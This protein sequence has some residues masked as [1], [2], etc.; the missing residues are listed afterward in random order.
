MAI[1][2][3]YHAM[4]GKEYGPRIDRMTWCD[5]LIVHLDNAFHTI[6]RPR[7]NQVLYIVWRHMLQSDANHRFEATILLKEFQLF[8]YVVEQ[9]EAVVEREATSGPLCQNDPFNT[10]GYWSWLAGQHCGWQSLEREK[11]RTEGEG[12]G[13]GKRL[14]EGK[15]AFMQRLKAA[16]QDR[17]LENAEDMLR[18]QRKAR[19]KP[20]PFVDK[21]GQQLAGSVVNEKGPKGSSGQKRDRKP[22]DPEDVTTGSDSRK[23][24]RI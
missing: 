9:M 7:E 6:K 19:L 14:K 11:A 12:E 18:Q 10:L 17:Q 2:P 16:Y 13:E 8:F 1:S 22:H 15:A 21:K 24:K 4:L 20:P 3:K 23:K 5:Y